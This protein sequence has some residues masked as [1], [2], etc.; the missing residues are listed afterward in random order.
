M[1]QLPTAAIIGAGASGIASPKAL[2]ERGLAFGCYEASGR[3]GGNWVFGNRNGMSAA[4]RDLHINTSR[5]RMAFP[6]PRSCPDFPHHSDIAACFEAY[7]EHAGFRDRIRFATAIARAELRDGEI[8]RLTDEHGI[9]RDHDMLVVLGMGNSAMGLAVQS[10]HDAR[11]THLDARRGAAIVPRHIFGRPSDTLTP[12]RPMAAAIGAKLFGF[13]PP[14]AARAGL[15]E[16]P[17]AA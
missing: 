16:R 7:A 11:T 1:P 10:S 3:V 2:H 9:E 8:W 17:V 12:G 13:A 15:G 6:M 5:D 4:S 14:V